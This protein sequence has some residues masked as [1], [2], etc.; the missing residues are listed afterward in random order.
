M[1]AL[2]RSNARG[3]SVWSTREPPGSPLFTRFSLQ[4]RRP[5]CLLVQTKKKKKRQR[6]RQCRGRRLCATGS[7]EE[8]GAEVVT[9]KASKVTTEEQQEQTNSSSSVS[10]GN[11][12]ILE[13]AKVLFI[14]VLTGLS[15][16]AGVVILNKM[17][18]VVEQITS[19]TSSWDLHD[20][21]VPAVGGCVV[22]AIQYACK[23]SLFQVGGADSKLEKLEKKKPARGLEP[24]V[25][26]LSA[27]ITL[28]TGASLGPEGP[29]VDIGKSI[30]SGFQSFLPKQSLTALIAAGSAAGISAGFNAPISGVFFALETVLEKAEKDGSL[31]SNNT[32]LNFA[33]VTLASVL[34]AIVSQIGLGSEPA[35]SIP[36]YS[37]GSYWSSAAYLTLGLLSGCVSLTFTKSLAYTD[38]RFKSITS[39]PKEVL[40]VIGG[41]I[42]GCIALLCP[43]V[44]YQGF[45]NFN[46]ILSDTDYTASTLAI[47]CVAKIVATSICKASGLQGGI[48]APSLFLGATTGS[49][50]GN[51]LHGL[52]S[53]T[54]FEDIIAGQQS[55]ALVGMASTLAAV[56]RVPL[57]ST[58]LLFELTRDY[59]IVLP[60]L[61]GVA[62]SFL[63]VS[64]GSVQ[65]NS[66][67]GVLPEVNAKEFVLSDCL[68]VQADVEPTQLWTLLES[69]DCAYFVQLDADGK[70]PQR[71]IP[72]ARAKDELMK[73]G[74]DLD[75]EG[76]SQILA[77]VGTSEFDVVVRKKAEL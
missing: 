63:F 8:S 24:L 33:V 75:R 56:C 52:F 36:N 16:G 11:D 18:G 15:T 54:K 2:A 3:A 68:Q 31:V 74:T 37:L 4:R 61:F 17:T 46:R 77:K 59:G 76:L 39:V 45:E 26:A 72:T 12:L 23:G 38:E 6:Q 1:R 28:G 27:A 43:E 65:A 29:S 73:R 41:L 14:G 42:M 50:Y 21:L 9:V 30:A 40:P 70:L 10:L 66:Q 7:G 51:L 47:I 44:T 55:F 5:A 62:L 69:Y 67:A 32:A 22:G 49:L 19:G 48:Y 71:I 13:D 20:L 35:M 53:G 64:S 34:A 60:S 58:L 25:D 57:T